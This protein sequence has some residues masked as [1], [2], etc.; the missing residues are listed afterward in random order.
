[1]KKSVLCMCTLTTLISLQAEAVTLGSGNST[2]GRDNEVAIGEGNSAINGASV[3]IGLNNKSSGAAI[4]LGNSNVA[5]YM[6]ISMGN[7]N[8]AYNNGISMGYQNK[9]N[10]LR[11][12]A[13]GMSNEANGDYAIA[14]GDRSTSNGY[15]SVA[16]GL[17]NQAQA[18]FSV[19]MGWNTISSATSSFSI[20]QYNYLYPDVDPIHLSDFDPLFMV[21]N[22]ESSSSRSDAFT[23]FRN[24]QTII[25]GPLTV[26]GP[27]SQFSDER[28][29]DGIEPLI[30]SLEK[31][32]RLQGVSYFLSSDTEQATQIGFIAQDIKEIVPE[33]VT[34]GRTGNYSVNYGQITALLAEATKELYS[35]TVDLKAQVDDQ[36]KQIDILLEVV[37]SIQ[38]STSGC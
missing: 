28:L 37:C 14:I 22:G 21:G 5:S 2:A 18:Q 8:F 20:G 1:M 23:V 25:H 10:G 29:K 35:E 30:G 16:I 19:A 7:D 12:I 33:V 6:G 27:I 38:P 26:A 34:L 13:I 15:Q 31:V 32:N 3:S 36:S 17:A 4:S 24:G 11:S 9:A